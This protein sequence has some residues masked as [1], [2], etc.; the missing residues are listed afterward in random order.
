MFCGSFYMW[1]G[2]SVH[3]CLY[4]LTF[5]KYEYFHESEKLKKSFC[6][7]L[8]NEAYC[9][10]LVGFFSPLQNPTLHPCE[11]VNKDLGHHLKGF[12]SDLS[13]YLSLLAGGGLLRFYFSTAV[14]P[15]TKTFKTHLESL[16]LRMA[17]CNLLLIIA[18]A[19]RSF[20][21]QQ[22]SLSNHFLL[23]HSAAYVWRLEHQ[24]SSQTLPFL[25][26]VPYDKQCW[27]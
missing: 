27:C 19:K 22:W 20:W 3:F 5:W 6:S 18:S 4:Q 17:N 25:A 13:R 1:L 15:L 7:C 14:V 9:E 2:S 23:L 11:T 12:R 10:Y 21:F 16:S 8:T 26:L 24:W